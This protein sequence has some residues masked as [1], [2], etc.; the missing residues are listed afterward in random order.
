MFWIVL[1]V[2]L[3]LSI[4]LYRFFKIPK[5]GS[6]VLVNGG[7]KTGKSTM[8]V[9]FATRAYWRAKR[10]YYI[11]NY[12]AYPLLHRLPFKKC[13]LMQK[14]EYPLLYSNIPLAV[15]GY[16]PLTNAL[17]KREK[18]F[19]YG[20]VCYVGEFSLV[21]DSMSF[22]D[23]ELNERLLLLAKLFGHETKGGMMIVDTQ[24]ISDCH[25]GLRRNLDR[26]FYIHHLN[27]FWPFFCVAY[28]R[29][30]RYSE[31]QSCTNVFNE[32]IEETMKLVII[33]KKVWKLFDCYCYSVLTD[34]LPVVANPQKVNWWDKKKA[35]KIP[36][37][38]K[39]QTI[40]RKYIQDEEE[41]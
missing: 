39:F 1:I 20:S 14:R 9:W 37:L 17:I 4:L 16:T 36:S 25:F 29:E 40:E 2:C 10:K 33:P 21:A 22:K 7:V 31:E 26:Y 24:A 30:M 5:L 12:V 34:D 3:L 6:L 35:N 32:D 8:S 23:G 15:K 13:K 38:K 11:Y 18:R 19:R 28:V 41:D 27:K